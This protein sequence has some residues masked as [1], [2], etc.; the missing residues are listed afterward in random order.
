MVFHRIYETMVLGMH[1]TIP[2][3]P[4]K[5]CRPQV[6]KLSL[7]YNA[8]GEIFV[9]HEQALAALLARLR[10]ELEP[11]VRGFADDLVK[12]AESER[13]QALYQARQASD[14]S[15]ASGVDAARLAAKAQADA[16]I[17]SRLESLTAQHHAHVADLESQ[18]VAASEMARAEQ[19]F[20]I[21]KVREE[22]AQRRV[23][24]IEAEVSRVRA[25]EAERQ[26]SA[27]SKEVATTLERNEA[28]GSIESSQLFELLGLLD[29]Q[30]TLTSILRTL[31]DVTATVAGR[32]AV[33]VTMNG[34]MRGWHAV[35]F[36]EGQSDP[37]NHVVDDSESSILGLAIRDRETHV[38][39]RSELQTDVHFPP[40][41]ASVSSGNTAV[42]VPV[43]IGGEPAVVLYADD[44]NTME[45]NSPGQWTELVELLARH[46][47]YRLEAL[48]ADRVAAWA[49]GTPV[50]TSNAIV[51]N[52]QLDSSSEPTVS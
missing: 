38:F 24:M 33:F 45:S 50:P 19:E 23:T 25:E 18:L 40:A 16:D 12:R 44:S 41:F 21:A 10:Q 9:E 3:P 51:E 34:E 37:G 4:S 14:A 17:E 35:G 39:G 43:V 20:A 11:V 13:E 47:G 46:A 36:D 32:A 26:A 30:T 8:G 5:P 22:E 49:S 7:N 28:S 42:A 29:S 52:S 48:T 15:V 6:G 31:T 27:V 1:P 2:L